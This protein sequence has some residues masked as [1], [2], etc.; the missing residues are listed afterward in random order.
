MAMN[1][2]TSR[3]DMAEGNASEMA[4]EAGTPAT[5]WKRDGWYAASFST[6]D[7]EDAAAD[8]WV[9]VAVVQPV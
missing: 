7:N 5:V 4:A 2:L 1:H 8:G 6:P 3:R 9:L